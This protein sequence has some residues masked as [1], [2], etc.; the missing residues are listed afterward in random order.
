[1]HP[2][3]V[4]QMGPGTPGTLR[5]KRQSKI[6]HMQETMGWPTAAP[7]YNRDADDDP[8]LRASFV[9]HG[10]GPTKGDED[11]LVVKPISRFLM[12]CSRVQRAQ[13][14]HAHAHTHTHTHTRA[15]A[16]THTH[17]HTH[18]VHRYSFVAGP[19][20]YI[21]PPFPV[22]LVV[23]VCVDAFV[24]GFLIG[25]SSASGSNAGVIMTVRMRTFIAHLC[26]CARALRMLD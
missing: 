17:T 22:T 14:S 3:S 7:V 9:D 19:F 4:S 25:I 23:A 18:H 1:M 5:R 16:H 26:T 21:A 15:R 10:D 8:L 11:A 13:S 20:V 2:T 12:F 24:D 6:G